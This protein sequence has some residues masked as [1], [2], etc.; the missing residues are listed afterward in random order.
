MQKYLLIIESGHI[1]GM[2]QSVSGT[3]QRSEHLVDALSRIGVC[4]VLVVLSQ[5]DHRER[6]AE[7][8]QWLGDRGTVFV[9]D[10]I[11]PSSTLFC[12]ITR[13]LFRLAGCQV[14]ENIYVPNRSGIRQ[15][16]ALISEN[17]YDLIVSRYIRPAIT[18]GAYR[19]T[20]VPIALDVDDDPLEMARTTIQGR[21]FP[22]P[23][24]SLWIVKH[25]MQYLMSRFALVWVIKA[26][27]GGNYRHPAIRLL[28][29]IPVFPEASVS[30]V[31]DKPP[32]VLFVGLL[33]WPPNAAGL[34]HFLREVWPSVAAERSD[35][36][37]RVVGG[38]ADAELVQLM[39]ESDGVHYLGWQESLHPAYDEA[40]LCVCPVYHGGGSKIKVLEA[41][42][43]HRPVVITGQAYEG[44]RDDFRDGQEL[45][46]ARND[47][48]FW[49]KIVQL[50]ADLPEA[51]RLA[52]NG[53]E[54]VVERFSKEAFCCQ[55]SDSI[56]AISPSR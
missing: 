20:D 38:G 4:D 19:Q 22:S 12:R 41:M 28:P 1:A 49:Q 24:F 36:Q 13:R 25:V 54:R 34:I 32:V 15:L 21:R 55:V 48:D 16:R 52:D 27:D 8:K 3:V 29:N 33:K 45:L 23:M 35:A 17:S 31:C 42:A 43:H 46:V 9:A 26:S 30:G 11:K 10:I 37:L 7:L 5:E 39:E 51:G 47:S 18:V 53:Y 2:G 6:V 40:S 14:L 56:A 50:L 44:V